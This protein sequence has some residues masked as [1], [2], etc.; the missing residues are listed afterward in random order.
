MF[1]RSYT[2]RKYC[3]RKLGLRLYDGREKEKIPLRVADNLKPFLS[4]YTCGPTVYDSA[5]IGH[6]SCYV[7]L[8]ILQRIMRH[9]FR[10][11][12]LTAM[13]IT[14]IDDKIIT[15]ANER[16]IPWQQL[17]RR[18]EDEF[19]SDLN[20]LNVRSPDIK[21]RVTEHI[22]AI[23]RFV[24]TL[25]DKGFAYH[26]S[27]GSIY[28]ETS[29]YE[30]YGKL[31]KVIMEQASA[32]A[33]SQGGKR[34]PSDFALWKASKPGEPFWATNFGNGRP[35]WHIECS[36]MASHVFGSRL[37]FHAGGLDLRFPHHENE[38]TQSCCYHDVPDWVTHWIHTGQLHLE[39]QTHKMSKSLKN[40][41]SVAELLEKYEPDEFRML[42]LLSHYRSAIEFGPESMTTATN[43]LRKF[44][45][46]FGDSKA[47][48]DG[49][50]PASF[51]ASS[52]SL[53]AKLVETRATIDGLLENDFNTASSILALGDLVSAVQKSINGPAHQ[54]NTFEV[55]PLIG[56]SN[57]GA[58]LAVTEYIREQLLS[59]GLCS[60]GNSQ[61]NKS[62]GDTVNIS[63]ERVVDAV[64]KTRSEIRQRAI[65]TKDQQ[66]F[67]I[68]DQLR[69]SL[70]H[71]SIEVKDHGKTSSW[72][73]LRKV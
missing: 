9:N 40:T 35:G 19:W 39:G 41:I 23:A 3:T 51:D 5:H 66:L 59:Y 54:S 58:V 1:Q 50:K 14:D 60:I 29:K 46:F 31:Q 69:D 63:L 42:C 55:S 16:G 15:R 18:Y 20:R 11:P 32:A 6:A 52:E 73:F 70:K 25:I 4:F 24:K 64:V 47:Y 12:L 44:S 61:Q 71:S 65:D 62:I 68:C 13:N 57:V 48:I 72:T 67:H 53:L 28:F 17:A 21:L 7:R 30:R 2:I 49:L 27:D 8:D 36:T 26:T 56:A 22:P 34:H 37:D 43:V 45:S 33:N 10:L 38:E